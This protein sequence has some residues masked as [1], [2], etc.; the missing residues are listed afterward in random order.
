M[1]T[2]AFVAMFAV[3]CTAGLGSIPAA[4]QVISDCKQVT[5][6]VPEPGAWTVGAKQFRTLWETYEKI[7]KTAE[8]EP[9]LVLCESVAPGAFA[10]FQQQAV[11]VTTGLL[12]LTGGDADELAAVMS[13]EFG[14]L[15]HKHGERRMS[16]I[17][18]QRSRLERSLPGARSEKE[19][20]G[21]LWKAAGK[22]TA[23]SRETEKE[24]DDEGFS[25]SRRA[26]FS[27]SGM[28]RIADKMQHKFGAAQ[29]GYLSTHPGW[30]ERVKDSGRLE[31]NESYRE[32][33]AMYFEAKDARALREVV[34]SWRESIPDSGAAAYYDALHMLMVGSD[35]RQAAARLDEAVGYFHGEGLSSIAQAYQ[36]ES[37]QAPLALCVQLFRQGEKGRALDCLQLLKTDEEERQFREITGWNAF[38][39]VPAVRPEGNSLYASRITNGAVAITN[40][41]RLAT[42]ANLPVVRSW[43]VPPAPRDGATPP[44]QMVCSPDMC[45]CEPASEQEREAVSRASQPP[46]R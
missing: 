20:V 13:H 41:K 27:A 38:V 26:G 1:K 42:D 23:F 6:A 16:V 44:P 17:M 43:R 2:R 39:F 3:A 30:G 12:R 19:A 18:A 5:S 45:N 22:I 11:I 33:A 34:D 10:L 36:A 14:H 15:I 9:T 7:A 29:G 37:S 8:F 24:A 4:A 32:R 25:L 28:R 21:E 46:R 31:M 35:R 40:C